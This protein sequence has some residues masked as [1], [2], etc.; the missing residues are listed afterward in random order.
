MPSSRVLQPHAGRRHRHPTERRELIEAKPLVDRAS[1]SRLAR[2]AVCGVL[3]NASICARYL[4]NGD[5]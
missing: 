4:Y 2:V 5:T 1:I 3:G